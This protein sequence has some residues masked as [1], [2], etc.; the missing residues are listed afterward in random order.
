M[1][2][3]I[4]FHLLT[5]LFDS[6]GS[7]IVPNEINDDDDDD[8][9]DDDDDDDAMMIG[10]PNDELPIDEVDITG[11]GGAYSTNPIAG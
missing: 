7:D 2:A 6:F 3:F 5:S 1:T 10:W 11:I 4:L 8:F 9:L